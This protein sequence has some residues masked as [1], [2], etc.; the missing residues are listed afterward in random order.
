L[1]CIQKPK[2][3]DAKTSA[4]PA[5]E[6]PH[7]GTS[8][9][10]TFEDHQALLLKAHELELVKLKKEQKLMRSTDAKMTKMSAQE[11]E[12]LWLQEMSGGLVPEDAAD[13][14][15]EE[16]KKIVG[17]NDD[18][19]EEEE[20]DKKEQKVLTVKTKKRLLEEKMKKK[21][22]ENEKQK[23]IQESEIYRLKSIKKEIARKEREHKAEMDKR[24]AERKQKELYGPKRIS[25]LKYEEPELELKLSHEITGNLRS[26]KPEGNI[27]RDRYKSLQK[28]NIVETRERAK[29]V[30]LQFLVFYFN[31]FVKII[32]YFFTFRKQKHYWTKKFE[33]KDPE[34]VI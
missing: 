13:D 9:N 18:D 12:K 26:L 11:I 29:Y 7:P 17:S 21:L 10:P 28:R 24:E 27:L 33:K 19:D 25:R 22:K 6:L 16:S 30:L 32:R 3:F 1:F 5:I 8:Y 23:R 2:N 4:L 14:D 34:A 20:D 15:D 31:F